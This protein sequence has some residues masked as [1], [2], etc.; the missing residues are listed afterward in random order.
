MQLRSVFPQFPTTERMIIVQLQT[1]NRDWQL[2]VY[3]VQK[4]LTGFVWQ[5]SENCRGRVGLNVSNL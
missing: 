3:S 4:R 2:M 1:K 5:S